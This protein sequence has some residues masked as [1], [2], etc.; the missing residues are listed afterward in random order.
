LCVVVGCAAKPDVHDDAA[1]SEMR[2]NIGRTWTNS[3]GMKLTYIP[4]GEFTMGCSRNEKDRDNDEGR[5]RVKLTKPFMMGTTEVT[6]AQ[7]KAVMGTTEISGAQWKAVPG[8]TP[9]YFT[10]NEDQPIDPVN[11]EEAA[12]FCKKLSEKEGR[13]Y[14]LPTEAE[15]EYACRAGTTTPFNTGETINTDQANYNGNYPYGNGRQGVDRHK[16]TA[17]GS[18]PPNAWGL[19]DMHGNVWEW[20]SD[21]YGPY[22]GSQ[23]DPQ[24]PPKGE[25]RVDRGG[26]FFFGAVSCTSAF[27][28]R[29]SPDNRG[30]GFGVG[31]RVVCAVSGVDLK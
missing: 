25:Y 22:R 21:W 13:T 2:Q 29:H 24:G 16:T 23:T 15:W 9:I 26:S 12:A 28:D 3:I 20:C 18:F 4:A 30:I 27:R 8:N 1:T 6:G 14:R 19:Y 7:W 10:G 31:F 5:H 11:W 17:V